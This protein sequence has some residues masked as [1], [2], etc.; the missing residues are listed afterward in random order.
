MTAVFLDRDGVIVQKAP[1]GEYIANWDEL[2]FLPDA[3][4]SVSVLYKAG[5]KIFIV[6]NQ[7]GVAL[8]RVSLEALENMHR[9]MKAK[10]AESGAS[11]SGIYFCPHDICE[12]CSCRKPKPGMLLRAAE[13]HGLALCC[14]WMVG[15]AASDIEAGKSAGCKTVWIAP[16]GP[17]K[18]TVPRADLV[19]SDLRSAA[20]QILQVAPLALY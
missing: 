10:F 13:D 12:N 17:I 3:L 7:R 20:R 9:Q 16:A 8:R 11:I 2:R 19:A 15:D 14:C 18:G 1:E 6:T 5:Y 4:A